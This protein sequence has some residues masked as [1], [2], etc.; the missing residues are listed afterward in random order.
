MEGKSPG[1]R[2][3]GKEFGGRVRLKVKA[4]TKRRW[5]LGI[6]ELKEGRSTLLKTTIRKNLM[7]YPE[8]SRFCPKSL[9]AH[10]SFEGGPQ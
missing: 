5:Q 8:R 1:N 7:C 6:T 10:L 9:C 4:K 3:D 2:V